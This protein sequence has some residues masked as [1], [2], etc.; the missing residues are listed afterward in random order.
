M[1]DP[2]YTWRLGLHA[3]DL[4][5]DGHDTLSG[6]GGPFYNVVTYG[7][8]GDGSTDDTTAIED[9]F[10]AADATGGGVIYFPPTADYYKITSLIT[11]TSTSKYH[12]LGGGTRYGGARIHQATS[13]TGA[14]KFAPSSGTINRDTTPLIE[15]LWI[16][17]AGGASSGRG[18]EFDN[19]GHLTDCTIS[20]FYDG[21]YFVTA[22]YYSNVTRCTLSDCDNSAITLNGT[23][24]TVIR[25]CRITGTPG[26]TTI[27]I[28]TLKYGI[29]VSCGSPTGIGTRIVDCSIEYFTHDGI[30]LDGGYAVE[31]VGNY[32]ETQQSSSGHAH[33]YVGPSN[34][35]YATRIESNYFQGDGT[36][37]FDA[38]KLDHANAVIVR[39][40]KF[41]INGAIG[42][43]ST[44]NTSN[45][46]LD[47]NHNSPS[48]TFSLPASS[49]TLDPASP[50][51]SNPMTTA[52]DIIK[53]GASGAAARLGIGSSGQVL[54][55]SGG[56]PVWS[57][58]SDDI[59]KSIVDAKGDLIAAT[60]AD[61][62][63]RVAVGT[64]GYRLTADS[65][66]T[67]GVSW[68]PAS[69]S[70]T[71]PILVS[72]TP[73]GSPLVFSDLIQNEAGTDLVYA[74]I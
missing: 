3:F 66:A 54:T 16:T 26:G 72:D 56:A 70:G 24:N 10:D 15:N 63:A 29:V 32:F 25:D 64:D 42:I 33:V 57:T 47:S 4:D 45:V 8:V 18:I 39:G 31:V 20:G 61:T 1:V 73:A 34:T 55:V 68:Q 49:Y 60:A 27:P 36:G 28:S 38:I 53:G 40:N 46:L 23:N 62:V 44:G 51:L 69:S 52:G 2:S 35:C 67:A 11:R 14:F 7:A 12:L 30:Y 59:A 65:G 58:P 21:L 71:G 17:G 22:S 43:S 48:G 9:T 19:D 37:G 74:D 5:A 50:P 13:N 41:G 6:G